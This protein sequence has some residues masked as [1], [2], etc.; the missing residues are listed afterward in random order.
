MIKNIPLYILTCLL[1]GVAL[2]LRS[3]FTAI[4]IVAL[5]GVSALEAV[6]TRK[7]KDTDVAD[8]QATL[9]A[10]K[11]KLSVIERDITNIAERAHAILGDF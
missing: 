2:Y 10:H 6:F 3:P 9:A 5:W 11:A 1:L 4:A 7:N 8:I